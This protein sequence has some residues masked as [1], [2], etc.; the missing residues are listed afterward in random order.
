[1][2]DEIERIRAFC[3][4]VHELH[5]NM[6]NPKSDYIVELIEGLHG[7]AEFNLNALD[8]ARLLRRS[9]LNGADNWHHY[10]VSSCS[11]CYNY[12]IRERFKLKPYK[13]IKKG[14]EQ[15]WTSEELLRMQTSCLMKAAEEIEILRRQFT[16]EEF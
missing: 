4:F 2:K 12:Q 3:A 7:E 16:S 9:L 15:E 14:K 11:L 10:S 8:N 6:D 13:F 1:M 5:Y